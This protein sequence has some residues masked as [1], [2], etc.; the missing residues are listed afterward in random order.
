M[1]FFAIDGIG[2]VATGSTVLLEITRLEPTCRGPNSELLVDRNGRVRSWGGGW[3]GRLGHGS[4]A[5][6]AVPQLIASLKTERVVCVAVGAMHS[7]V[8]TEAG[9]L[10]SFGAN[11]AGQLGLG[12]ENNVNVPRQVA[13]EA[14]RSVCAGASH[15]AAITSEGSLLSWGANGNGLLGHGD[16][17][18]R[19][20]PTAVASTA[21]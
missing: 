11:D 10:Y 7:M 2:N 12:H 9:I 1:P 6:V 17:I 21:Q 4:E 13:I 15:T 14:V 20:T 5:N 16:T 8:V 3:N 19:S 18:N